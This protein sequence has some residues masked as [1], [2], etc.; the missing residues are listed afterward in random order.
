MNKKELLR[1]KLGIIEKCGGQR[2]WNKKSGVNRHGDQYRHF[3]VKSAIYEILSDNGHE[4]R[5]EVEIPN[6]WIVDVIDADTA[7]I[8]EVETNLSPA[9]KKSKVRRYLQ[10]QCMGPV[11][12][13]IIF[14]DPTELPT[15]I[16]ELKKELKEELIL[17]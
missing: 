4:V 5:T 6:E 9:S 17:N 14:F 12:E 1:Q 11:I 7:R 15:D 13:D 3:M 16:F 8:Y 2:E 10:A